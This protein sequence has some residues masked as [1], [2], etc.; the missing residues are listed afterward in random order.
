VRSKRP[1]IGFW[2][3]GLGA[4]ISLAITYAIMGLLALVYRE[5]P[6]SLVAGMTSIAIF[7]IVIPRWERA[8]RKRKEQKRG[9]K[10]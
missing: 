1:S 7:W 3:F 5:E 6:D 4:A 2:W 10:N 8:I 9:K